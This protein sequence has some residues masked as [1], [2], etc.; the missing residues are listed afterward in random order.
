MSLSQLG[1]MASLPPLATP[2]WM[3]SVLYSTM[4]QSLPYTEKRPEWTD[5]KVVDIY[6]RPGCQSVFCGALFQ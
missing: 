1:G 3:Q 5:R 6:V 2:L 4:L